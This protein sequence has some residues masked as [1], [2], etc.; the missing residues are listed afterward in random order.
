MAVRSDLQSFPTII[1]RERFVSFQLEMSECRLE[2][3]VPRKGSA[4]TFITV[5]NIVRVPQRLWHSHAVFA[6][7]FN[8]EQLQD[9]CPRFSFRPVF[10][11]VGVTA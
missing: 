8:G 4:G 1:S 6:D 5:K 7:F 2:V 11:G 9:D 10:S 3:R